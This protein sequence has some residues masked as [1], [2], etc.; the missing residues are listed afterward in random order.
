MRSMAQK[1]LTAVGRVVASV[2]QMVSTWRVE[3]RFAGVLHAD[4][5]PHG[6]GHADRRCAADDHVADGGGHLLDNCGR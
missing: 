4:G 6:G 1:R 2:S 3:I 5:D